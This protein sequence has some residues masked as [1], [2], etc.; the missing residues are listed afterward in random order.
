MITGS[1]L[2]FFFLGLTGALLAGDCVAY[3]SVDTDLCTDWE[4]DDLYN[5]MLGLAFLS[6][7]LGWIPGYFWSSKYVKRWLPLDQ[8]HQRVMSFQG[9]YLALSEKYGS[10]SSS[11]VNQRRAELVKWV[12]EMTPD[13]EENLLIV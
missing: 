9:T 10:S 13:N 8:E 11:E 2:S 6:L 5:Q 4:N 1:I 7:F 12:E 3:D